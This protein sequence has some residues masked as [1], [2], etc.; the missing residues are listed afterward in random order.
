MNKTI[1]LDSRM[2]YQAMM[3]DIGRLGVL[4]ID[5][6]YEKNGV[7]YVKLHERTF[8]EWLKESLF[9]KPKDL[10]KSRQDVADALASIISKTADPP[11]QLIQ[12]ICDRVA[13]KVDITGRAL[14]RDHQPMEAGNNPRS[15]QGGTVAAR[16]TGYG[17]RILGAPPA[18]IKCDHAILREK[19]ALKELRARHKDQIHLMHSLTPMPIPYGTTT[20]GSSVQVKGAV[21][22]TW[23]CIPD[24]AIPP[25]GS[26]HV[27]VSAENLQAAL[28]KALL[29]KSG[30]VVVELL[31]DTCTEKAGAKQWDYSDDGIKAQWQ[32]AESAIK[33]AKTTQKPLVISFACDDISQLERMKVLISKL[34]PS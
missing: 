27:Q 23:S 10:A 14:K 20:V 9:T 8:G 31:P 2:N 22:G 29:D 34:S 28:G 4:R 21:A 12:N 25:T 13:H 33:A 19:T 3:L 11:E 6:Q 16:G 17:V 26:G 15:L 24:V 18:S 5:E 30:A 7:T 32:V 1:Q